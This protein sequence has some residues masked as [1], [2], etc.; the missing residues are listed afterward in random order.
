MEDLT[1][2]KEELEELFE[3]KSKELEENEETWKDRMR[4][5]TR[6]AERSLSMFSQHFSKS[7]GRIPR[8]ISTLSPRPIL[9][10]RTR[11]PFRG[12]SSPHAPMRGRINTTY[13][14]ET[15]EPEPQHSSI[16][17]SEDVEDEEVQ[18]KN[19][20]DLALQ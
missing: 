6:Q 20:H 15:V 1:K 3:K 2:K 19:K 13:F 11:S 4:E 17:V 8:S 7:S 16:L 5:V 10:A 12:D 14:P 18:K 9:A